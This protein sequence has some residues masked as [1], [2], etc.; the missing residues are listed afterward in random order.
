MSFNFNP[1]NGRNINIYN[2][3]I[4]HKTYRIL[5]SNCSSAGC[6]CDSF[7]WDYCRPILIFVK[8]AFLF[9]IIFILSES[10]IY[11]PIAKQWDYCRTYRRFG[12]RICGFIAYAYSNAG[13]TDGGIGGDDSQHRLIFIFATLN[14]RNN[15]TKGINAV[16]AFGLF[17]PS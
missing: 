3:G 9:F 1:D 4:F 2:Y 15:A 10:L 5:I 11:N 6:D 12:Y 17:W 13:G 16:T 14:K 7:L 8:R